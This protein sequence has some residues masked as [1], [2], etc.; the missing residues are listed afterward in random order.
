MQEILRLETEASNEVLEVNNP[1][2]DLYFEKLSF[3]YKEHPIIKEINLTI[4]MEKQPLLSVLVVVEKQLYFLLSN[5]FINQILE[6]LNLVLQ[7]FRNI[8]WGHGE[9]KLPMFLKKVHS[10]Q[11]L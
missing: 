3:S 1:T 9:I 8:S 5:D 7:I 10:C 11:E 2:Q 6:T 4:P